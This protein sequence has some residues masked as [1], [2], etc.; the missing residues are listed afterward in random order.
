VVTGGAR[1][2][3]LSFAQ[4]LAEAG[5]NVVVLDLI[6]PA[7]EFHEISTMHSVKTWYFKVDVSSV[8]SLE[9]AFSTFLQ[10]TSGALDICVAC[11]GTNK[12]LSFTET[13]EASFDKL[14]S[15]NVKGAFFT[16]QIAAKAMIANKTTTGSIIMVASI[17]AFRAVRGQMSSAYCGTKGAVLSMCPP[18][19]V[20]LAQYGIRVNSISPG[21]VRTEMTGE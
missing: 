17:A 7:P 4:G 20:E 14:H 9:K 6:D 8:S 19:A 2:C 11:A 16:A 18:M 3:G 21:Y 15:V 13:D 10:E 5:A 12:N 1:G